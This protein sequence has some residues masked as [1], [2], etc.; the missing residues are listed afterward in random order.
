MNQTKTVATV[1]GG[2]AFGNGIAYFI[3]QWLEYKY[4]IKFSDP[5]LAIA[6]GGAVAAGLILYVT[7]FF[8]LIGNGVKFSFYRVF[9][10]KKP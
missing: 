4:N 8:S 3:L 1:G 6:M 7:R 10:E 2:A 5:E 9:P